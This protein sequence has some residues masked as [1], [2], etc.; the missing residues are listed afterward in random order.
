MSKLTAVRPY[1]DFVQ[2]LPGNKGLS[3][4]EKCTFDAFEEAVRTYGSMAADGL[5]ALGDLFIF[6]E[7]KFG[8]QYAQA[9][10]PLKY[11]EKTIGNAMWVC[12]EFPPSRRHK[13]LTFN[14]HMAVA[15]LEPDSREA[16]L[17]EAEK[18]DLTV[19]EVTLL[20]KER[21]PSARKTKPK[22]V[23]DTPQSS[24]E[25]PTSDE[26]PKAERI[27][28]PEAL[29]HLDM[30]ISFFE[31]QDPKVKFLPEFTEQLTVRL[32]AFRRQARRYGFYGGNK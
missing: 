26:K 12:S 15:A 25:P 30:A 31:Q 29:T 18:K 4:D 6:G 13:A 3:I 22:K 10:E 21:H 8:E 9:L 14:H 23:Q 28:L 11:S 2:L 19:K 24:A 32:N 7:R 5:W 17:S 1:T 16:I 27:T 20:K